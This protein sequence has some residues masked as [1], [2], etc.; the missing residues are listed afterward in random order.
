MGNSPVLAKASDPSEGTNMNKLAKMLVMVLVLIAGVISL[1]S[2]SASASPSVVPTCYRIS[3]Y[4][5]DSLKAVQT[6]LGVRADG[7]FGPKSCG[8]L[9]VFQA[10]YGKELQV[11]GAYGTLGAKTAAKLGVTLAKKIATAMT[12]AKVLPANSGSGKRIVVSK[13]LNWVW[14]VDK[15]GKVVADQGMVF[16]PGKLPTGTYYIGWKIKNN[17]AHE[18]RLLLENYMSFYGNIGFHKIP[19]TIATGKR[20]HDESVLGKGTVHS[21]GCVRLGSDFSDILW[22]IA[23]I[24]TP[25]FVV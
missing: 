18:G 7:D 22:K 11:N 8:S 2:R 9:Q 5:V 6:A 16:N 3:E 19:I 24:G 4:T 17:V 21:S 15:Y 10:K 20:F 12:T 14:I 13:Q 25:V 1:S 23:G